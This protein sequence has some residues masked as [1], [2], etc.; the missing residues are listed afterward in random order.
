[1]FLFCYNVSILFLHGKTQHSS[2][3]IHSNTE[4]LVDEA[5]ISPAVFIS[6]CFPITVNGIITQ[7]KWRGMN[8]GSIAIMSP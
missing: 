6:L 4:D 2:S 7:F 5:N 1:M 3:S 8:V